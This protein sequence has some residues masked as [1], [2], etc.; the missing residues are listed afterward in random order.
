VKKHGFSLKIIAEVNY[1]FT[2]WHK[3]KP[4]PLKIAH[5]VMLPNWRGAK[6]WKYPGNSHNVKPD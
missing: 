2:K 4:S 6:K 1:E 3:N 5:H